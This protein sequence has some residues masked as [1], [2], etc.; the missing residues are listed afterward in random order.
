[1]QR[2]RCI[3]SVWHMGMKV[4]NVG[5]MMGF[6][7]FRKPSGAVGGFGVAMRRA[8]IRGLEVVGIVCIV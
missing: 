6:V 1:M 5:V 8:V 4:C 7:L 2:E 3:G